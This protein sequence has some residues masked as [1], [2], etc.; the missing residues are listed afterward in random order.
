MQTLK[1]SQ[2]A[3]HAT[4]AK[5][6]CGSREG[7]QL[8]QFAAAA[9]NAAAAAGY[10]RSKGYHF[11]IKYK[12]IEFPYSGLILSLKKWHKDIAGSGGEATSLLAR[13]LLE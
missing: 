3:A 1:S 2:A 10:G 6:N 4:A 7:L 8:P 12:T 5:I 11:R 9:M 13:C